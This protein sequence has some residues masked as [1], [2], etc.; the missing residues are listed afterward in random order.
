MKGLR[1]LA[2]RLESKRVYQELA[3]YIGSRDSNDGLLAS[4]NA[5]ILKKQKKAIHKKR[6]ARFKCH[7]SVAFSHFIPGGNNTLL[8]MFLQHYFSTYHL[9]F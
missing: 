8:W 4:L 3:C 9:V 1:Q 5:K 7:L 6:K 2:K